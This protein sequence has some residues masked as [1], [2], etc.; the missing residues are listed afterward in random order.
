MNQKIRIAGILTVLL[1]LTACASPPDGADPPSPPTSTNAPV[2]EA[3]EDGSLPGYFAAYAEIAAQYRERYGRGG[4]QQTNH[5]YDRITSLMGL[6][7]AELIDFDHNGTE[8]LLLI[9]AE[10]AEEFH[11]YAYGVWTSH[12]GRTATQLCENQIFSGAQSYCPYLE[13]VE[14]EDGTYIG[15]E[16]DIINSDGAHVYR[17]VTATGVSDAL[18]LIAPSPYTDEPELPTVNGTPTDYDAFEKAQE[19]FLAGAQVTRIDLTSWSVLEGF[20]DVYSVGYGSTAD[21]E[22]RYFRAYLRTMQDTIAALSGET[23]NSYSYFWSPE[24][25]YSSYAELV[26]TFLGDCGEPQVLSSSRY[27]AGNDMPALG[28]LCV[29]RLVD[30]DGDGSDELILAWP[31]DIQGKRLSYEYSIWT[32]RDGQ[33]VML[34]ENATP[35]TAYEP[36]LTLYTGQGRTYISTGYDT[37]TEQV[38]SIANVEYY[39]EAHEFDGTN[40]LGRSIQDIPEEIRNSPETEWIYFTAWSYRWAAGMD[41]DTDSQRVGSMTWT[42]INTIYS[43]GI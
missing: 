10:S 1:L 29:V 18:T 28:G 19:D 36:W 11:S 20:E 43:S 4:L 26:S 40:M 17:K 37:N 7:I 21:E 35:D 13:L 39:T 23:V 41:W 32:K 30:M 24:R 2:S 31:Q 15:E 5:D 8:E 33:A 25:S 12:D 27:D 38:S 42:A 3:Q 22:E 16:L 6:C 9:W 34:Y 14:R